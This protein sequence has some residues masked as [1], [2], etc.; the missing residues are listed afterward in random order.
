MMTA[1]ANTTCICRL[2]H[3]VLRNKGHDCQGQVALQAGFMQVLQQ[4]VEGL[5]ASDEDEGQ[6]H[7]HGVGS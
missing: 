1:H 5:T 4:F 3:V 2:Q 7:A 6:E